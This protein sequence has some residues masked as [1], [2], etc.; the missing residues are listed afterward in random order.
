MNLAYEQVVMKVQIYKSKNELWDTLELI[1]N[2]IDIFL[3]PKKFLHKKLKENSDNFPKI[4]DK[5]I[6]CVVYANILP[7]I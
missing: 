6:N 2:Q 3:F 4:I 7:N 1:R 5:D